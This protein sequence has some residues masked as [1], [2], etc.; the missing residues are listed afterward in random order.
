[1]ESLYVELA[2]QKSSCFREVL[3][4]KKAILQR[5]QPFRRSAYF[6]KLL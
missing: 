3:A 1:M 5:K 6:E 2:F 4:P